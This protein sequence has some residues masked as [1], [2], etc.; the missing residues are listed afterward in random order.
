V[1][2]YVVLLLVTSP[3][4]GSLGTAMPQLITMQPKAY[5]LQADCATAGPALVNAAMGA[6]L[7]YPPP[8]ANQKYV[9]GCVQF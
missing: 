7:I 3:M 5:A 4:P 2:W 8:A 1:S 9:F 6:K